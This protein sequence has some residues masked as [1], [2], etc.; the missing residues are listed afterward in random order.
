VAFV[1]AFLILPGPAPQGARAQVSPRPNVVIV[2]TDDQMVGSLA[3]MPY[4]NSDPGGHWVNF[5]NGF[6]HYPLCCP[7]RATVLSGLYSHHHGVKSNG[8]RRFN[9]SSTIATWLDQAG[10]ETALVGK[11]LNGY[12]FS[13]RPDNY[14]PPGWDHWF[15]STLSRSTTTTG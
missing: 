11:Y 2:L 15:A 4:L 10:Y 8:G 5:T 1:G 3:R 7:S 6:V 9:D 12:P 14:I 13:D